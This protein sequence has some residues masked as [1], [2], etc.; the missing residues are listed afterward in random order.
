MSAI[1]I[2]PTSDEIRRV[3]LTMFASGGYDGTSIRD[4]AHAVGIKGASMYNHFSSKEE[5]LWDLTLS[6]L[7]ALDENWRGADA[8][9]TDREPVARLSA[10]V[11][12][13]VQFHTDRHREAAIINAQLRSLAP[14]H[15]KKAAAMQRRYGDVLTDIVV[16]CLQAGGSVP[17]VR[18]TTFAMLQMTTAISTWYRPDGPTSANRLAD[19]YVAL[20]VKMVAPV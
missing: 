15:R 3:A 16:D 5:I 6:A 9:L 12:A 1:G 19:H 11:R 10:F 8:A 14:D 18:V 4:I 13:H 17:D 20:A 2:E 7:E